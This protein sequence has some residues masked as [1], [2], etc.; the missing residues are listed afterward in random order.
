MD[1]VQYFVWQIG[2][3]HGAHWTGSG[4]EARDDLGPRVQFFIMRIC[5]RA[6]A[7]NTV[8]QNMLR[9]RQ[10]AILNMDLL[11]KPSRIVFGVPLVMHSD[12]P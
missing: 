2:E 8:P 9:L 4:L 5:A 6:D 7:E 12:K 11:S 3:Q 1:Q 10:L